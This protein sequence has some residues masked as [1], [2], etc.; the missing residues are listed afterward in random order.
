MGMVNTW[1]S[2][3]KR[4]REWDQNWTNY[5]SNSGN[6]NGTFGNT[7]GVGKHDSFTNKY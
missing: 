4:T 6:G 3:G 5:H 1:D 7:M 2:R